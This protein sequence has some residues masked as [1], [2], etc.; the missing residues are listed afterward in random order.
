MRTGILGCWILCV[1]TA[2]VGC[3]SGPTVETCGCGTRVCGP[4]I[5]GTGSCGSCSGGTT[6]SGGSCVT[7]GPTACSPDHPTGSCS[8]AGQTCRNGSCCTTE[9][10]AAACN[11]VVS[12]MCSRIIMCCNAAG[13]SACMS[14]AYSSSSCIAHNVAAGYNCSSSMW[15][16][17]TLCSENSQRCAGDI[18]LIAC[19]DL[20]GGTVNLPTSCNSF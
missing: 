6:C 5:C 14:W 10:G 11:T 19:S 1:F 20:I 17:Q 12:A 15:T 3:S 16:S 8:V 7:V 2:V 9:N 18:P 4:N 13:P